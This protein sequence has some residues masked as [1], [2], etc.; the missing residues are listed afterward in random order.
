MINWNIPRRH[1]LTSVNRKES[2]GREAFILPFTF[3]SI[4]AL[5]VGGGNIPLSRSAHEWAAG[6]GCFL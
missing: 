1:F 3:F 4:Y 2:Q 6:V 5:L